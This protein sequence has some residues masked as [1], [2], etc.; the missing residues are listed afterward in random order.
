MAPRKHTKPSRPA[1]VGNKK[2]TPTKPAKSAPT[3]VCLYL[4][5]FF[6]DSYLNDG[7]QTGTFQLVVEASRPEQAVERFRKRLRAIRRCNSVLTGP[8]TVYLEGFLPLTGSFKEGLL[9]NYES[10]PSPAEELDYQ[11]LNMVPEQG[12]KGPGSYQLADGEKKGIQPF[13]DFGGVAH[14][15]AVEA[16]KKALQG[17]SWPS[18]PPRPHLTPED[19]GKAR[20]E[21]AAQRAKKAA[22]TEAKKKERLTAAAAKQ[23]RDRALGDTLAELGKRSRK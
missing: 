5:C 12:I 15:R 4:G 3:D 22:E 8:N 16:A 23:K 6:F 10:R 18:A 9:V 21:A 7:E 2:G 13:V 20:V 17:S 11:L 19:R 14:Q 1:A